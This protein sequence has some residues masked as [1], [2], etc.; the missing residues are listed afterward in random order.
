MHGNFYVARFTESRGGG[1]ERFFKHAKASS[2]L[3]ISE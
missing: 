1:D 2:R 3:G